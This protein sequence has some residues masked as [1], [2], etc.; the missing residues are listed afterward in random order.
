MDY[1]SIQWANDLDEHGRCRVCR[2][3][4]PRTEF[5]AIGVVVNQTDGKLV[6]IIGS[7]AL[8]R[9]AVHRYLKDGTGFDGGNV[10]CSFDLGVDWKELFGLSV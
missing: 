3:T 10:D 4:V 1:G 7:N 8:V 2:E 5:L 6:L 9:I